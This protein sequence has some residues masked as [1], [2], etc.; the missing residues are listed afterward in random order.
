MASAILDV[1]G[2]ELAL[3]HKESYGVMWI[4]AYGPYG[5]IEELEAA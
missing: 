1:V 5:I 4:A 3:S 2:E